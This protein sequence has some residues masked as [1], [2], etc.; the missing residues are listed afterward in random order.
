M[1]HF[2]REPVNVPDALQRDHLV[3]RFQKMRAEAVLDKS[4]YEHWNRTHPDETPLDTQGEV[5]AVG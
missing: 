5:D 4:T 3:R 1:S 2:T